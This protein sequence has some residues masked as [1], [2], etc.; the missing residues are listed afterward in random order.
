VSLSVLAPRGCG[1]WGGVGSSLFF[2]GP[3]P[4][5]AG[6]RLLAPRGCPRCPGNLGAAPCAPRLFPALCVLSAVFSLPSRLW[7][8]SLLPSLLSLSL[9][10]VL[11]SPP[12]S[13]SPF[14]APVLLQCSCPACSCRPAAC[15][16]RGPAASARCV[17]D[18]CVCCVCVCVVCVCVMR[19]FDVCGVCNYVYNCR[20][21]EDKKE[22]LRDL[23]GTSCSS[24]SSSSPPSSSLSC[25]PFSF[26]LLLL[27][28]FFQ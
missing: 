12:P 17:C 4:R 8:L 27:F 18:V 14:P 16:C 6:P 23:K 24:S 20:V 28:F 2:R 7:R 1:P 9:L 19:V 21:D 22:L 11:S 25:S 26:L 10:L 15:S 5:E 3:S 13:L